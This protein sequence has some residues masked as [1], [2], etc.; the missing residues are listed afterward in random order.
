MQQS[1]ATI[2]GSSMRAASGW[3]QWEAI[4]R[5][6][7]AR[8]L[9]GMLVLCF[10]AGAAEPRVDGTERRWFNRGGGANQAPLPGVF[11][12]VSVD[13]YS[14]LVR[15]RAP[16]GATENVRVGADTYDISK[17]KP[18]DRI[19]VDFLVPE[20]SG[21]PLKAASIWPVR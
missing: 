8:L 5:A 15:L 7:F 14:G 9:L 17:L 13:S 1:D 16:D 2:R 6:F 3:A 20:D 12:V 18:G 11:T 19:Q 21:S 10:S 4:M